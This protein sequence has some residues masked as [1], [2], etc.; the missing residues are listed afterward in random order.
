MLQS[1]GP[2]AAILRNH[3]AHACTDVTG[4]G[5]VGHLAEMLRAPP[6]RVAVDGPNEEVRGDECADALARALAEKTS[7]VGGCSP[8]R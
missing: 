8:P 1:N 4:F 2:A 5:V 3:G 7:T 6:L